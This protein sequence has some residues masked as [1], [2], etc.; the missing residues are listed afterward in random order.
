M[1]G[2][3]PF[4][5]SF[6][7]KPQFFFGRKRELDI[8]SEAL[9]NPNSP[10]RA[11]FFTG[12]R[13]CGKTALLERLS[14]MAS[15][16]GWLCV[17]VHSANA[18]ESI[19][20]KLVGASSKTTERVAEPA[21][22]FVGASVKVGSLRTSATTTYD[23]LDLSEALLQTSGSL[24]QHAGVFITVDEVQ[25][26]PEADMENLCAAVQMSMRKGMPVALMLAGLPESKEVVSAYK[27]CTF[28]RRVS[29]VRLDSLLVSETYDA[30]RQ[31]MGLASNVETCEA[32]IDELARYS[33][34]YPYLMQLIGFHTLE[35]A[36]SAVLHQVCEIDQHAV[37]FAEAAA[38]EQFCANVLDPVIADLS[39]EQR[40]YLRAMAKSIDGD[41]RSRTGDVAN[42]MGKEQR[43]LSAVRDRLIRKRVIVADGRGYVRYNLPRMRQYFTDPVEF[44]AYEDD[45]VWKHE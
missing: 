3:N 11:L 8:V 41:G 5:P 28:M 31:L 23:A 38:Y 24:K 45:D 1:A 10:Y 44:P 34:G 6:G 40:V 15:E 18:S 22:G 27:G 26:I 32:A 25:K 16:A 7:G 43:Q 19:V 14:V 21:V 13:G 36:P 12:N 4:N 39:D 37:R 2:N 17:D 29:D 9:E 33:Q 42:V 35:E 20:R 30:F